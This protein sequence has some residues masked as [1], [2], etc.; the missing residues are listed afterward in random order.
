[1]EDALVRVEN[2]TMRHPI[3]KVLILVVME[4]ALV[5]MI[6]YSESN[7]TEVLILVVMEDALVR[8][9]IKHT[10]RKGKS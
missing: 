5:Q 8:I 9:I 1:M 7:I 6:N 3:S 4:D 2:G 10:E